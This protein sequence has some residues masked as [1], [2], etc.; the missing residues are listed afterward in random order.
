MSSYN[1]FSL[2][3]DDFTRDVKYRERAVYILSLFEK[4]DRKPSLLLDLACGTGNFSV[5][6]AKRDIEVIG[7]DKSEDML[8]IAVEKNSTLENPVMYICQPAEEL[9]LYGTVDGA[10]C[11]L[12]SLNHITDYEKF[13]KA[14]ANVALFLEPER[15]FIFD[16]N[17]PY[18]H[19]N[20]LGNN[21]FRLKNKNVRCIWTN[22]YNEADNTVTVHLDFLRRTGLFKTE[23]Y[24]E[25]F[26]E[27]AYT[28]NEVR[29]A[30]SECGLELLAVY[31]E[32]TFSEPKNNSERN[33]YITRR[34][35]N[36]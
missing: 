5:E 13:K 27:R 24:L 23:E 12:D 19:K 15:L 8:N 7:V 2:F 36:G 20:V 28:D 18:K 3:Y 33:I 17:T 11:M 9:E 26:K 10:V 4:F 25:K 35:N 29:L 21:S 22:S 1:I 31:G 16:L 6:F 32:N 34:K 14:I 30:L